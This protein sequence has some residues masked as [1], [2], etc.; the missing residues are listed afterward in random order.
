MPYYGWKFSTQAEYKD[1]NRNWPSPI[2]RKSLFILLWTYTF[3]CMSE[4]ISNDKVKARHFHATKR[5]INDLGT[6]ND[7]G[8]LLFRKTSIYP[9]ELQLKVEHLKYSYHFLKLRNHCK[10]EV[11]IYNVFDKR[12][13]FLIFIVR[14][15]YID[16]NIPKLIFFLLLLVNFLE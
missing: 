12:D 10:D 4:P 1:S 11:F 14:M 8:V 9:P 7:G 5:F 3:E 2:L 13:A 16:S 15:L 6:L